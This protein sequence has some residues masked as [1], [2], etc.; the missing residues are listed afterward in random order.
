MAIVQGQWCQ[1]TG[2]AQGLTKRGGRSTQGHDA[3]FL[4]RESSLGGKPLQ[5]IRVLGT[6]SGGQAIENGVRDDDHPVLRETPGVTEIK[7][8]WWGSKDCKDLCWKNVGVD[9]FE[10]DK[11]TYYWQ[12][13]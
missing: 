1:A 7:I 9:S 6:G 2:Q 3:M 8:H 11:E 5:T 12:N 10:H 13:C 4:R